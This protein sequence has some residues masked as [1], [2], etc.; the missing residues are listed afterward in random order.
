MSGFGSAEGKEGE[1]GVSL[2]A[3]GPSQRCRARQR[4]RVGGAPAGL[5]LEPGALSSPPTPFAHD[6]VRVFPRHPRS[7]A[8]ACCLPLQL[9]PATQT[10]GRR[11]L[12]VAGLSA[13]VL[14]PTSQFPLAPSQQCGL[15]HLL[16]ESS[17]SHEARISG[18]TV[19]PKWRTYWPRVTEPRVQ[20]LVSSPISAEARA[21]PP[22]LFPHPYHAHENSS[23]AGLVELT[24]VPSAEPRIRHIGDRR[25]VIAAAVAVAA[26]VLGVPEPGKTSRTCPDL[27]SVLSL[28]AAAHY[29]PDPPVPQPQAEPLAGTTGYDYSCGPWLVARCRENKCCFRNI[30]N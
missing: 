18:G 3:P 28:A 9:P 13:P 11:G 7:S 30:N 19:V 21:S 26:L 5:A 14:R 24:L 17:S 22:S 20:F 23:P 6:G 4:W 27:G 1:A 2:T 16:P 29:S 12:S 25:L 15:L 8:T 10:W